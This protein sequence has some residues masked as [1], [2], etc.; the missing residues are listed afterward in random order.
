MAQAQPIGQKPAMQQAPSPAANKGTPPAP[1]LVFTDYA[2][3]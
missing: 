3:I 2:S 1:K